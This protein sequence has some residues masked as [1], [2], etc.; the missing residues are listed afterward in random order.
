[1]SDSTMIG[2]T[3]LRPFRFAQSARTLAMIT[4]ALLSVG[5]GSRQRAEGLAYLEA[6]PSRTDDRAVIQCV[7]PPQIRQLGSRVTYL[8][9]PRVVKTSVTDCEI[10]GGSQQSIAPHQS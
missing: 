1:M 2:C 4:C 6:G 9:S 3:C 10:R 5:C 7:L 8:T